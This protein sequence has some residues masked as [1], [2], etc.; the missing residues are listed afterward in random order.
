MGDSY[1]VKLEKDLSKRSYLD[2]EGRPG[3]L[4]AQIVWNRLVENELFVWL[5]GNTDG[6]RLFTVT[7]NNGND[8]IVGFTDENLVVS[9]VNRETIRKNLLGSFGKKLVL[10]NMSFKYL[11]KILRSGNPFAKKEVPIIDTAVINPNNKDFFI[12]MKISH[13]SNVVDKN[14][15]E[16]ERDTTDVDYINMEYSKKEKLFVELEEDEKE[17]DEKS[18]GIM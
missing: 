5:I 4:A 8:S 7:L 2:I 11:T 1:M 15:E 10:V 12:P 13:L 9:Y 18:S 16:M 14:I 3:R 6:N 17:D